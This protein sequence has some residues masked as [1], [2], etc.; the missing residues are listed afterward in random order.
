MSR[1]A[2]SEAIRLPGRKQRLKGP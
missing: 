2:Q 1:P